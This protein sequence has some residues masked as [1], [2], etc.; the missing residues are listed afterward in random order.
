MNLDHILKI[1]NCCSATLG[2]K[3]AYEY[4]Y[5]ELSEDTKWN[6]LKI[7][8]FIRT[9]CRNM[10]IIKYKKETVKKTS[11]DFSS[12][13]KSN[14]YLSLK[15]DTITVCTKTKISPCLSDSEISHIIEQIKL[16]CNT[17]GCS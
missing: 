14:K 8:N 7:N 2:A 13:H 3:Y 16:I 10:E 9:L 4:K 6:F 1:A 5:G 15:C 17:C 11:V 12:L